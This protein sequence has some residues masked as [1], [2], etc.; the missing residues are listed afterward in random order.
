MELS[1]RK[2]TWKARIFKFKEFFCFNLCL[3]IWNKNLKYCFHLWEWAVLA[4]VDLLES[5]YITS[6]PSGPLIFCFFILYAVY[7]FCWL[8]MA[9]VVIK[10][11]VCSSYTM[12]IQV[13]IP[14]KSKSLLWT[15]CELIP[16]FEKNDHKWKRGQRWSIL[17][18]TLHLL[19]FSLGR[20]SAGSRLSGFDLTDFRFFE[21]MCFRFRRN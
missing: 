8:L 4:I 6:K 14:L 10:W 3:T 17:K 9:V 7:N 13:R 1:K 16:K 5:T 11:L 2:N 20:T 19:F 21:E 12:M 15:F 18:S